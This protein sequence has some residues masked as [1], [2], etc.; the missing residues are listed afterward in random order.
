MMIC[1][2]VIYEINFFCNLLPFK[3]AELN[4]IYPIFLN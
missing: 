2:E 1:F 3:K 4:Y